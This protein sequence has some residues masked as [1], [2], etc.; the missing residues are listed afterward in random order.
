MADGASHGANDQTVGRWTVVQ[1]ETL[2]DTR[3]L[4]VR[5]QRIRTADGVEIP[6]Y[7][8]YDAPD[9]VALLALT[10]RHEVILVNQYR[11]GPA[12]HMPRLPAGPAGPTAPTT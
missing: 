5:R 10:Q 3:W 4:Q 8:L 9:F 7:Y 2:V 12:Q 11:H 6:E 1:S